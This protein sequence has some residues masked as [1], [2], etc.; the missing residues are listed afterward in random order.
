M[1]KLVS[2]VLVFCM[3]AVALAGCGNKSTETTKAT[4]ATASTE[5][6]AVSPVLS[7]PVQ[8]ADRSHT[9][10]VSTILMPTSICSRCWCVAMPPPS[11]HPKTTGAYSPR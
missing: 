9:L 5:A 4:E 8:R 2:S 11:L 1:K 10:A 7:L 6:A 3:I